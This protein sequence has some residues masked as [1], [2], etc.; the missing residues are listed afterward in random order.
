V[1]SNRETP[2]SRTKGL[3]NLLNE[4]IYGDAAFK[5]I[6]FFAIV[7]PGDSE[8]SA[9]EFGPAFGTAGTAWLGQFSDVH[10][11]LTLPRGQF[12]IMGANTADGLPVIGEGGTEPSQKHIRIMNLEHTTDAT[13]AIYAVGETVGA[14][15]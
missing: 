13:Y 1:A 9:I 10:S 6:R 3:L 11:S 4:E 5:T 2:R 8:S 7:H 12:N 15:L 14:S